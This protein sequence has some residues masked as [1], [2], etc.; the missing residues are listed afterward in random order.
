MA[1]TINESE[2]FAFDMRAVNNIAQ[3]KDV[4]LAF[5]IRDSQGLDY[6]Y[7]WFLFKNVPSGKSLPVHIRSKSTN[8]PAGIYTGMFGTWLGYTG[9]PTLISTF[10]VTLD[11]VSYNVEQ[12]KGGSLV[13]RQDLQSE[14]QGLTIRSGGAGIMHASDI[15][16]SAP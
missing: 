6:D 8:V 14:D 11:G 10:Q 5:G 3:T 7:D 4:I 9:S 13:N 1:Y 15:T 2:D 12:Y 16:I